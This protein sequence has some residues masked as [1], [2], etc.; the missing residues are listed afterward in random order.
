MIGM[1]PCWVDSPGLRESYKVPA[2]HKGIEYIMAPWEVEPYHMPWNGDG[3]GCG[4]RHNGAGIDRGN[5]MARWE[6][7]SSGVS[8]RHG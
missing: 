6:P 5:G 3:E 1:F 8:P 4:W 7:T 2:T